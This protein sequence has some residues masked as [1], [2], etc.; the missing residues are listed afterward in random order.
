VKVR[1]KLAE[2]HPSRLAS[3]HELAG[4]YRANGQISK[5]VEMLEHVVKVE[6]KLAEDHPDRLASQHA[7]AG[8]YQDNGQ[9]SRAV[10]TLEHVV[11]VRAK[12]AEDHPSRLA[13]RHELAGAYRANGQITK[14]V[15]LLKSVVLIKQ[16]KFRVNHRSRTVSEDLLGS[17]ISEVEKTLQ[18]R[19]RIPI[20]NESGHKTN[21]TKWRKLEDGVK[22]ATT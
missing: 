9:I 17:L 15:E 21:R 20:K 18:Q 4:A 3:Q 19:A 12:L 22:E 13:S 8:A 1:E 2:D 14:A 5:A 6:G 10:E 16:R 7:L 11:K